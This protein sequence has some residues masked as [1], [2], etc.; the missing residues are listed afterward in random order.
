MEKIFL[1]KSEMQTNRLGLVLGQLVKSCSHCVVCLDGDLGA[2][3]TTFAK[4]VAQGL[5][6]APE[7]VTSPTF[8]IMNIYEQNGITF[9]HFDLYRLN[10]ESELEAIGFEEYLSSRG[11]SLIE[12][13]SLFP[14]GMP[15]NRL[16]I[17]INILP[18]GREFV[19]NPS[20][21]EY[22]QL[23]KGVYNAYSGD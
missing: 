5:G 1:I 14:D 8:N 9:K 6:F 20:G 17:K 15:E 11:V 10:D 18:E 2:G 7:E 12:W 4:S 23:C 19:F 3:K 16:A 22:E 13:S 21:Q